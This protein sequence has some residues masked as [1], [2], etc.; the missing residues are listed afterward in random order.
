MFVK[1]GITVKYVDENGKTY[2]AEVTHIWGAQVVNLTYTDDKGEKQIRSSACNRSMFPSPT[3]NY[4]IENEPLWFQRTAPADTQMDG[5]WRLADLQRTDGQ[6]AFI[7]RDDEGEYEVYKN[8]DFG[9][10]AVP[11]PELLEIPA[12]Q[13]VIAWLKAGGGNPI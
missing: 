11:A 10:P 2:P 13:A 7:V 9:Q 4:W 8:A 12:M 5:K 1:P 3:A 6:H